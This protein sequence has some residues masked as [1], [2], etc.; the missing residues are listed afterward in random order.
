VEVT[1]GSSKNESANSFASHLSTNSLHA[2]LTVQHVPAETLTSTVAGLL[3]SLLLSVTTAT[4][5]ADAPST[6]GLL[7]Y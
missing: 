3:T 7:H 5:I 6:A 1:A 2:T 4:V